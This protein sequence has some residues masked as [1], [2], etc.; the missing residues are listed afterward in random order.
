[1]AKYLIG[2]IKGP[3]GK[4]GTDGYTPV[5]GVDYFDGEDGKDG[6][7]GK[8]G[9]NGTD[10]VNGKDGVSPTIEVSKANGVTTIQITDANGTKSATINDGI[11]G[12][13]GADGKDGQNGSAGKDGSNGEDGKDGISPIITVTAITGG[14]RISITDA[15]GTKTVDVM[16]GKDGSN[17]Q[18]GANGSNGSN[19]QDGE[20]GVGIASIKQTTTSTADDGNNVITVTLTNGQT[21]TF[22]VQ[23][24]SKGS[25]GAAG[26][27]GVDGKDGSDANVTAANIKSA[28]GYDPAKQSEVDG[29][30]EEIADEVTAR[31]QAIA[32]L[33]ARLGQQTV[34][35]AEGTT[36]EEAEAWLEENGDTT[37]LYMMPDETFWW[38][39]KTTEVVEGGPAYTNLLPL[40]TDADRTTIM[41]GVGYKSG[42]RLS[43]SGSEASK[44]GAFASGF[45]PAK[46]GDILRIKGSQGV[47]GISCYIIS[48]DSSNT[49]IGHSN[50]YFSST[51]APSLGH[52]YQDGILTAPLTNIGS[53][54]DAIR[55]SCGLLDETVIVT[56]NEEIKEGG[57]TTTVVV[58]K[59]AS[60]GHGLIATDYD[61]II[62]TLNSITTA[63]T[64]EINALKE[65]VESGVPLTDEE[66]LERIKKWDA[67]IYDAHIPVFQLSVEKNAI[68]DSEKTVE[69]V[70]AKYDALMAKHPQYITKTNLGMCSDGVTPVYR[71]DF[72]EPEPHR[73]TSGTKEWSE[74]KSKAIIISGIHWEWGGIFALY[75]ALEE[76]ADNPA[77]YDLRRNTHLIVLPVC[78]PYAVANMSVRN[79]NLVEIHRNF[80]VDFIYPGEAGYI[81]LGE[82]S[83]GGTEPLSEVETQYIDNIFK[84]NTDAA[85]FLTCHSYQSDSL[86]GTG[87]MWASPATYYMC[88]M[89]YRLADKLSNNWMDRYG[90]ILEQGIADYKTE[91]LADWDKR[92]GS[93]YLSTTNGTETKQATKYGIQGVNVEVCD[94]FWAHGTTES[95]EATLSSFTMSRG[96]EVYANFLLT[97]FG[98]YDFKD[99]EAYYK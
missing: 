52:T 78:N 3:A 82:R 14:H 79:A 11:D 72:R 56:I 34:L 26:K 89:G 90:D 5:K 8:D 53:G 1:M 32:S 65:A 15:N 94:T 73:G 54:F 22:I 9:S 75:N 86:W 55:F 25:T 16:D 67:P 69:A 85:F 74:T 2:N 41:N 92:F 80:E 87:F 68:T 50:L 10:G 17:G 28:L 37:K 6:I 77:L 29:L 39:T 70:Y 62:A 47:S 45:I 31:E 61:E 13:D 84:E 33:N 40:A 38:Y 51:D 44:D 48:Y 46:E 18:A 99:K 57:G 71:Y 63:H 24:G 97:A 83:H 98:V 23:N 20:D 19:G 96:A 7:D 88:N 59:W 49:K 21:A 12:Q 35:V 4:D 42:Y 58:E 60:T 64:E 91:N 27:D 76:I 93:A 81:E 95:P 30:S 66:K 36:Q 43:S